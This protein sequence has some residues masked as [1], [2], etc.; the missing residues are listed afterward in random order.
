[1]MRTPAILA[2]AVLGLLALAPTPAAAQGQ[3]PC[4]H[5]GRQ[6]VCPPGLPPGSTSIE[7]VPGGTNWRNSQTGAIV[8]V[9]STTFPPF[10]AAP[11][12]GPTPT[13]QPG[14]TVSAP[15]GS[16]AA[17]DTRTQLALTAFPSSLPAY[18]YRPGGGFRGGSI[19][20]S[21]SARVA[22]LELAFL[23]GEPVAEQL[24]EELSLREAAQR[25]IEPGQAGYRALDAAISEIFEGSVLPQKRTL[26]VGEAWQFDQADADQAPSVFP[27]PGDSSAVDQ[28]M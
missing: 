7:F 23:S 27:P 25:R 10:V 17:R 2:A 18:S 13:T 26:V 19:G 1:M 14:P 28:V 6:V 4:T 5:Q 9:P 21:S 11:T 16:G 24:M 3:G 20:S 12:P 22:L 15:P 8:F